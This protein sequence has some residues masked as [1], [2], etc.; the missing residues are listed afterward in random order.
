MVLGEEMSD[1]MGRKLLQCQFLDMHVETKQTQAPK[2]LILGT[3]HGSSPTTTTF[4]SA[5][6]DAT[7][8]THLA[9]TN[10]IQLKTS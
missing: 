8:Q 1:G 5:L 2:H 7:I 9:T 6:E 4:L 3:G 10:Q